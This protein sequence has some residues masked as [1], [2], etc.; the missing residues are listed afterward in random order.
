MRNYQGLNSILDLVNV[1]V[2]TCIKFDQNL[3]IYSQDTE[4]KRISD[5]NQE[6]Y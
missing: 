2:Y 5:V 4:Q 6:I 3:F 1:N